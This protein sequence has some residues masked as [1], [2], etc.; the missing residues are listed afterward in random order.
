MGLAWSCVLAAGNGSDD[1]AWDA[2]GFELCGTS[3]VAEF[4]ALAF[5]AAALLCV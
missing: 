4:V 2:S 1:S 3:T 5:K